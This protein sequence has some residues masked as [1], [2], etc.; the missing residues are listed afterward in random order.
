MLVAHD[1]TF[2]LDLD[3]YAGG[4]VYRT[5]TRADVQLSRDFFIDL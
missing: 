2:A 4:H 5:G 3:T 1:A